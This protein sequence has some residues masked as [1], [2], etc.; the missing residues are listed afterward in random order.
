MNFL[1]SQ[2]DKPEG[3]WEGHKEQKVQS[4]PRICYNI[5]GSLHKDGWI[6]CRAFY[7]HTVRNIQ[8]KAY[9]Y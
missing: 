7:L 9:A 6:P 3:D 2:G 1:G 5:E 4:T 8:T